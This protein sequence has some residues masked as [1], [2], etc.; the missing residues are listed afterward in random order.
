MSPNCKVIENMQNLKDVEGFLTGIEGYQPGYFND[1]T[2]YL[3][4]KDLRTLDDS[5]IAS[6]IYNKELEVLDK[7]NAFNTAYARFRKC[8]YYDT[9]PTAGRLDDYT[10]LDGDANGNKYR[11]LLGDSNS[12]LI[13]AI[14]EYQALLES[15]TINDAK[16]PNAVYNESSYPLPTVDEIKRKHKA[17]VKRRADLDNKLNELN[18]SSNSI[19]TQSRLNTDSTIYATLLWTTLATSLVYYLFVKM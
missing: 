18:N 13:K 19:Y 6:Q 15:Y 5:D 4:V 9:Y 17:L 7:L 2:N 3:N 11:A 12:G 1:P 16:N 14:D 8:N 10:C